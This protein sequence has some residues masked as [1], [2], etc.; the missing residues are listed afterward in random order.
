MNLLRRHSFALHY[1][2][3]AT[4]ICIATHRV[5][6]MH[7]AIA[8]SISANC[9]IRM[10]QLLHRHTLCFAAPPPLA[11]VVTYPPLQVPPDGAA[12]VT[13][14]NLSTVCPVPIS[15]GNSAPLHTVIVPFCN[16]SA[17]I[18]ALIRLILM[19][20]AILLYAL[21]RHPLS[22]DCGRQ[23]VPP[24]YNPTAP[25]CSVSRQRQGVPPCNSLNGCFS[26]GSD[27]P[28]SMHQPL[29]TPHSPHARTLTYDT[30]TFGSLNVGG[31]EVTPNRLCH[32]LS[33][34]TP[35]PHTLSLQEFRPSSTS[36]L[37]DHERVAMYWGY[38]LHASSPTSKEGV[39]LLIHTS[40][41]PA[42]PPIR[43]HIPGRL[44]SAS[45][46][47]HSD[48]SMPSLSIASYYGPHT[49]AARLLCEKALAGLSQE[50]A[51]ILGDYNAVTHPSHTTALRAPMWPWL[52]ARERAGTPVDLI[53]PHHDSVPY[54]RVR[55]Y[56]GT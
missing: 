39:A 16:I 51:V 15:R 35:L 13:H 32:I 1:T 19:R 47:L 30:L 34:F 17:I 25:V 43:V 27:D 55:R 33:G 56:G 48:P 45:I 6:R 29:D 42:P 22:A 21:I 3:V 12:N 11:H 23:S 44:I 10:C 46:S 20:Q 8:V 36:T 5:L 40:I 54:T 18:F 31:V 52:V 14:V 4:A 2:H 38:H 7:Y 49:A 26:P 50:C 37:R 53:T 28:S 41:A 24:C 9:L